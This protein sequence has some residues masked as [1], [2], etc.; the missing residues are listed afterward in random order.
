[1]NRNEFLYLTRV[2]TVE[3]KT[4]WME[5]GDAV[6]HMLGSEEGYSLS[7]VGRSVDR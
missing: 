5:S 7:S 1:M 3:M 2:S 6:G 4:E